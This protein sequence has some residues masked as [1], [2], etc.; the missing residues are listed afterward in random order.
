MVSQ[1]HQPNCGDSLLTIALDIYLP[2]LSLGCYYCEN[3]KGNVMNLVYALFTQVKSVLEQ[4]NYTC[5]MQ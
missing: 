4:S 1:F 2:R 3:L 5:V